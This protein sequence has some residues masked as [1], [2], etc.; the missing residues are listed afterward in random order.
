MQERVFAGIMVFFIVIIAVTG[1]SD[2]KRV[3]NIA[4]WTGLIAAFGWAFYYGFIKN[5]S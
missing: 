4:R 5:Y 1:F 3:K 2:D